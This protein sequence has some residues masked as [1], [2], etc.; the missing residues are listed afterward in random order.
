M[1]TSYVEDLI[2]KLQDLKPDMEERYKAKPVGLFGSY[3]RGEQR[4]T[5]DIDILVDFHED[6]D[7]FDLVGLGIFLEE[8]LQ[9]KVDVVSRKALRSELQETILSEMVTL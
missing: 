6:A 3:V 1:K 2:T 8:E 9:Q 4:D 5:S 7:L